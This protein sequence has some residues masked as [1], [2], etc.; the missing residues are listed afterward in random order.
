MTNHAPR[1][2]DDKL[3]WTYKDLSHALDMSVR[4]IRDFVDREP[5]FPRPSKLGRQCVWDPQEVRDWVASH[6]F[7]NRRGA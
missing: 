3:V 4:G 7:K 1:P 6:V 5:S 2:I